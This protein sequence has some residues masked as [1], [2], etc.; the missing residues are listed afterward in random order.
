LLGVVGLLIVGCWFVR[1]TYLEY[2]R[3]VIIHFLIKS[4]DDRTQITVEAGISPY[5]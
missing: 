2:N 4:T 5:I 3:V 1:L